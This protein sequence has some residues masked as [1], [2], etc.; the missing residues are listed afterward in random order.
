MSRRV[1]RTAEEARRVILDAAEKRLRE[2]GPEAVRLQDVARAVGVS[3]PA[4]LHHFGSRQGLVEALAG[5]LVERLQAE[6]LEAL[7]GPAGEGAVV[8]QVTRV[9]EVMADSGFARLLAWQL[10]SRP[11]PESRDGAAIMRGLADAIHRRRT[12]LAEAEGRPPPPLEDSDFIVRLAAAATLGDGLY[13][14]L[15]DSSLAAAP[16]AGRSAR[17]RSWLGRLLAEHRA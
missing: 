14:P 5:R 7:R 8:A 13:G 12:Q 2:G 17:F 1:R 9:F 10:L 15:L 16:D 3:H 11:A 6:L 4:I